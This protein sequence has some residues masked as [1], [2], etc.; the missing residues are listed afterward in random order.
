MSRLGITTF[1]DPESRKIKPRLKSFRKEQN[2]TG[3]P[4]K[5]S[6]PR[7]NKSFA[8][9]NISSKIF[10]YNDSFSKDRSRTFSMGSTTPSNR[11]TASMR[12]TGLNS[13]GKLSNGHPGPKELEESKN[14]K[15]KKELIAELLDKVKKDIT[16]GLF[17]IAL[18][19]LKKVFKEDSNNLRAIYMKAQCYIGLKEYKLAIPDLLGIIQDHPTYNKNIYI[20][21]A[22]CFIESKDYTTAVRQITRGLLKFPRFLEGYLS[23]GTLYNQMQKWDKAISDF[24]EAISIGPTEGTGYLGLAESLIGK[25]ECKN[26]IKMLDQAL[27]CPGSTNLALLK[28]GKLLFENHEFDKAL[29]DLSRLIDLEPNNIEAHYFKAFSLLGQENLIDAAVSLE[30]VI[31]YDKAKKYTGAAIYNLGAIKIRQRDFYGAHFT[32]QR[33]VEQGIEIEEQKVLKGYVE[34][35]LCLMRRKFKEGISQL[36]KIIKKKHILLQ[37]YLGNCFAY[38]GYAYASIDNHEKSVK[39]L[40]AAQKLQDLDNSSMYNLMISQ[41]VSLGNCEKALELLQQ[42]SGLFP[43]NVEPF[44]YQA[45]IYFQ[46]SLTTKN[47]SLGQKSKELLDTVIKL[48]DSESDLYF[49]RGI[50]T[51]YNNKPIDAVYDFEQAID[52]AEDNVANHFLA[53]GLCS[54]KLKMFKEAIQDFSIAIQ[55]DEKCSDAYFFRGRCAFI[56]EDAELALKDFQQALLIKPNDPSAHIKASNLLLLTGA[57]DEAVKALENAYTINPSTEIILSKVKCYLLQENIPLALTEINKL[58]QVTKSP[59]NNFDI[60]VLTLV[61]ALSS[62]D[63]NTYQ[64][65]LSELT[66]VLSYKTEGNICKVLHIHWIRG[67]IFMMNK[68][69]ENAKN[70]FSPVIIKRKKKD[71]SM[72]RN[73]I[74]IIYN[75]AICNLVIGNLEEAFENLNDIVC[76]LDETD[77]GKVLL[78]M[79]VIQYAL[80]MNR[81]AKTILTEAFKYDPEIVGKYLEENSDV[82]VLPLSSGEKFA[83]GF[84]CIKI[85]IGDSHPFYVRPCIMIPKSGLPSFDFGIEE[86]IFKFFT[87]NTVKC[88]PETPWLNR[89]KGSIQFT[90]EIQLIE[91]ESPSEEKEEEEKAEVSDVFSDKSLKK[92]KSQ[93]ISIRSPV[94]VVRIHDSDSSLSE[95][96]DDIDDLNF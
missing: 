33:A 57:V 47:P 32:F 92:Y 30:Q 10:K 43:K 36:N 71:Q 62:Q 8:C 77:R 9:Y 74:E 66:N 70:E 82:E 24:Y 87:L 46:L 90:D 41:A 6:S 51:Y 61:Q 37:E 1:I 31:K 93:E 3:S 54:A 80:E 76:F 19:T 84:D 21:I 25:G 22:T 27:K 58:N 15:L 17:D 94:P 34:A 85:A 60:E 11:R 45:A 69:F 67:F 59:K 40:T 89:V 72:E 95:I 68:D 55:L 39:D 18:Q 83:E 52:K 86:E 63:S 48:R 78:I 23:R 75:L 88:K 73:N 35:I 28:R 64:K 2:N 79:G 16:I 12:M 44:A 49:Y 53:R 96:L 7:I 4:R 65:I 38:R 56:L 13:S 26:A 5:K 14:V 20:E 29:E 42:A 81:E 50:V 91:A